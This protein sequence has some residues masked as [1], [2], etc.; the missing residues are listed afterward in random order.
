MKRQ[1][2]ALPRIMRR[3]IKRKNDNSEDAKNSNGKDMLLKTKTWH[4]A[5]RTLVAE[6]IGPGPQGGFSKKEFRVMIGAGGWMD[7]SGTSLPGRRV[8]LL[9]RGGIVRQEGPTYRRPLNDIV[10][11]ST[12]YEAAAELLCA[13]GDSRAAADGRTLV[14]DLGLIWQRHAGL[15]ALARRLGVEMI[16]FGPCAVALDAEAMAGVRLVSRAEAGGCTGGTDRANASA[17][18]RART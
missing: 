2:T 7:R 17:G 6:V 13:A 3:E 1:E 10:F 9:A 12:P 14:I 4:Q 15:L 5:G 8:V 11:V 18:C 16:G